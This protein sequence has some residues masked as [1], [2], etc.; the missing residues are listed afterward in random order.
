MSSVNGHSS[1]RPRKFALRPPHKARS[2]NDDASVSDSINSDDQIFASGS[3][4]TTSNMDDAVSVSVSMSNHNKTGMASS[5]SA[6]SQNSNSN[7]AVIAATTL[8]SSSTSSSSSKQQSQQQ[9]RPKPKQQKFAAPTTVAPSIK[10]DASA[11]V[12]ASASPTSVSTPVSTSASPSR[13][14]KPRS[15]RAGQREQQQNPPPLI[16]SSA[17]ETA[18]SGSRA[19]PQQPNQRHLQ[20]Q[21]PTIAKSRS[22]YNSAHSSSSGH[23]TGS[24]FFMPNSRYPYSNNNNNNSNNGPGHSSGRANSYHSSYNSRGNS[25]PQYDN[26]SPA[27]SYSSQQRMSYHNSATA[28]PLPRLYRNTNI[29]TTPAQWTHDKHFETSYYPYGYVGNLNPNSH[30]NNRQ[31]ES[32]LKRQPESQQRIDRSLSSEKH[33]GNVRM[34][35]IIPGMDSPKLYDGFRLKQYT[36]LPD[37][38]PPLRRDKPVQVRIP[39]DHMRLVLPAN[40]RSFDFIPRAL[41]PNQQ[42]SRANRQR[43]QYGSM[44]TYSRAPSIYGGASSLYSASIVPS[45][46]PSRRSSIVDVMFSPAA[47]IVSRPV[48]PIVDSARPK[49]KLPPPAQSISPYSQAQA[50][51]NTRMGQEQELIQTST[52]Q[53]PAPTQAPAHNQNQNNTPSALL[54]AQEKP[55]SVTS[56]TP[57]PSSA[58]PSND[59]PTATST[60][61]PSAPAKQLADSERSSNPPKTTT[62]GDAVVV[63]SSASHALPNTQPQLEIIS[64]PACSTNNNAAFQDQIPSLPLLNQAPY[65]NQQPAM[66]TSN[67]SM[68]QIPERAIHAPVFQPGVH[69]TTPSVY[70]G[71]QQ[72]TPQPPPS[73]PYYSGPGQYCPVPPYNSHPHEYQYMPPHSARLVPGAGPGH[74]GMPQHQHQH[75]YEGPM[76]ANLSTISRQMNGMTYYFTSSQATSAPVPVGP[77]QAQSQGQI[78]IQGMYGDHGGD[79]Y[80]NGGGSEA[81]TGYY[82]YPQPQ[83]VYYPV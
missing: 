17:L 62:S 71:M 50:R 23:P 7:P 49:V 20:Q 52:I 51:S 65:A 33:I 37:H 61:V 80:Q 78:P 45:L 1:R 82:M 69:S 66:A 59:P 47:P 76:Q 46:A 42:K 26:T 28:A 63:S 2:L 15:P 68:A 5:V 19:Q 43:S 48:L 30:A 67:T 81:G 60:P 24:S 22:S 12:T 25:R 77:S 40:D 79:Y 27:G 54:T 57:L 41:R 3:S 58:Q 83:Q 13:Y 10:A 9:S 35:V 36:K 70:P 75:G 29:D 21:G 4:D 56:A 34:R 39:G 31:P 73:Q 53:S 11:S 38:R 55:Y 14:P 44:S 74:M 6:C 8:T 18:A 16:V 64:M 72:Q 32:G